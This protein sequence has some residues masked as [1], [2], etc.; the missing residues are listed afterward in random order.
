MNHNPIMEEEVFDE[1]I[2]AEEFHMKASM[3][4]LGELAYQSQ[5]AA[6]E[7]LLLLSGLKQSYLKYNYMIRSQKSEDL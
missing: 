1:L 2:N 7:R 5:R 4:Y 3:D 6:I